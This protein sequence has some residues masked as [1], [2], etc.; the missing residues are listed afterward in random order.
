[1]CVCVCVCLCT[2][3]AIESVLIWYFLEQEVG[4]G[5]CEMSQEEEIVSQFPKHEEENEENF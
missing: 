2:R 3:Q 1:M 5:L 4:C